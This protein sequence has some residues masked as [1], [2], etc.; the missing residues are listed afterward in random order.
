MKQFFACRFPFRA[1]CVIRESGLPIRRLNPN[2]MMSA[3]RLGKKSGILF[4]TIANYWLGTR[5]E[6]G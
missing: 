3:Y 2:A 1:A 5:W 4:N 6:S